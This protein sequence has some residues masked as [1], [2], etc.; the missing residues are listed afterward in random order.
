MVS[1]EPDF[2]FSYNITNVNKKVR[3][4]MNRER[5]NLS[6]N[7]YS[8]TIQKIIKNTKDNE[9]IILSFFEEFRKFENGEEKDEIKWLNIKIFI[10]NEYSKIDDNVIYLTK[11]DLQNTSVMNS[12]HQ[13]NRT[14]VLIPNNLKNKIE[15]EKEYEHINTFESFIEDYNNNFEYNF[16]EFND[17]K[18]EKKRYLC[19]QV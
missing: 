14:V 10:A 17:L 18:K 11:S 13:A 4:A 2:L 8:E 6:R 5:N 15:N 19:Y 7:V 12:I 3:S 1:S 9:K 16:I